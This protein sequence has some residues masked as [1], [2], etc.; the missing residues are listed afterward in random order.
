MLGRHLFVGVAH[1][2]GEVRYAVI[3]ASGVVQ[4]G[5]HSKFVE[6]VLHMCWSG[7]LVAASRS[8]IH[9]R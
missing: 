5:E 3:D 2:V 6:V 8:C 7:S 4:D 1:G 9:V